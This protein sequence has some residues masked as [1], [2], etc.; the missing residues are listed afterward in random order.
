MIRLCNGLDSGL[1]RNDEIT[2]IP[3]KAGIQCFVNQ[4]FRL[5]N[6]RTNE[7]LEQQ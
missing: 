2:V 6:R 5:L 7:L 4:S 1:R 3:A